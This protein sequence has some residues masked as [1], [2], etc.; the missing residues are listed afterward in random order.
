MQKLSY[1]LW[2]MTIPGKKATKAM[3]E[4]SK[5]ELLRSESPNFQGVF[6][7]M[8]FGEKKLVRALAAEPTKKPYAIDYIARHTL[9]AGG[10][11]KS[12][13]SLIDKNVVEIVDGTYRFVDAVFV[14][15]SFRA[16]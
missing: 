8:N 1:V 3:L 16:N 11:Q 10:I 14:R 5:N 9:S 4:K 12:L 7:E 2:N 6:M 13:K 15:G